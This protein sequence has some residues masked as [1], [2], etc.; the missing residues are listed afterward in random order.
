MEPDHKELLIGLIGST[1]G[2][3]K[4]LDDSIIGSSSTLVRRSDQ[5]KNEMM[6]VVKGIPARP[7]VP[8]LQAVQQQQP[9]LQPQVPVA[10]QVFTPPPQTFQPVPAPVEVAPKIDDGQLEFDLNKQTRYDDIVNEIDRLYNKINKLED[11]IDNL[12]QIVTEQK[13]KVG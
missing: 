13:K 10:P 1:Y 7:D 4:R 6:N 3:L 2:E 5:V 12:T 9:V 8:I 11:K